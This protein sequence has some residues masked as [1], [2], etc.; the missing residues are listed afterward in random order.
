M[1]R[2]GLVCRV[3]TCLLRFGQEYTEISKLLGIKLLRMQGLG[4]GLQVFWSGSVAYGALHSV[5]S[6][7][8]EARNGGDGGTPRQRQCP[9]ATSRAPVS[10]LLRIGASMRL[11]RAYLLTG[12]WATRNH[13]L[14]SRLAACHTLVTSRMSTEGDQRQ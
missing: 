13:R 9:P 2:P 4:K 8:F 3:G 10:R 1:V 5:L 12:T 11:L 14:V 7:D 6:A